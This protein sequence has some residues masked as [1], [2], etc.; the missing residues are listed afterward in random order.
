MGTRGPAAKPKDQRRNRNA[1]PAPEVELP[2]DAKP[3]TVPALPTGDWLPEVR[4]WWDAWCTT[5]AAVQ[6]SSTEWERLLRAL[7]LCQAY[8]LAVAGGEPREVRDAHRALLDAEKGLP[9]TD[10]ERRRNGI[11][12][13]PAAQSGAAPTAGRPRLKVV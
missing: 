3:S 5:P 11:Q 8:W 12:L 10:Y 2:A 7:P 4:R 6:F 1:R 13:K 9:A